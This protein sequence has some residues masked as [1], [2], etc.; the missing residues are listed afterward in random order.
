VVLAAPPGRALPHRPAD[1]GSGPSRAANGRCVS[2]SRAHIP[3][4]LSGTKRARI[5]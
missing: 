4:L 3:D 2:P 1:D 5:A